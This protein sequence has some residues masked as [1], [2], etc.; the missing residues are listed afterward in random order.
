MK[1]QS[2]DKGPVQHNDSLEADLTGRARRLGRL[3]E[4]RNY[5]GLHAM[6]A[7]FTETEWVINK[8]KY[9]LTQKPQAVGGT[10][11]VAVYADASA[12]SPIVTKYPIAPR[13]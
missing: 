8:V 7:G 9:R 1:Q 2:F 11:E 3:A 13:G 12:F 10:F 4:I 6:P 5:F